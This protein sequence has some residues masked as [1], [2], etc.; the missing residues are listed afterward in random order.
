MVSQIMAPWTP[1]FASLMSSQQA[2]GLPATFSFSNVGADNLPHVR[3]CVFRGFLF[4][5]KKTNVL[6]FTT[7]R[8]MMKLKDLEK[9]SVFEACFYFPSARKQFRF[10]GVV[11]IITCDHSPE[12]SFDS[13][14]IS[15]GSISS[16]SP[17]AA[18]SESV[19]SS[20][21]FAEAE[22]P[23]VELDRDFYA[24]NL[25]DSGIYNELTYHLVSPTQAKNIESIS[26]FSQ[27]PPTLAPPTKAEWQ[28]ERLRI[29]KGLS[30][31]MRGT[32]RQPTPGSRLTPERQKLIDS[33][34]RGVDGGSQEQDNFVVVCMFVNTV[35]TVDMGVGPGRRVLYKRDRVDH[36][37]EFE[38][39]P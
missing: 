35:D 23:I 24:D 31:T 36:W 34:S 5:D 20:S 32:F 33:I 39:C 1:S 16:T 9:N 30:R 6:T 28:N 3:T 19:S 12:V 8:R 29:W 27:Q 22:I 26:D 25:K 2:T 11:R 38:V 10:S 13:A 15:D 7:D 4:D 18:S 37:K 21:G 14:S 17:S